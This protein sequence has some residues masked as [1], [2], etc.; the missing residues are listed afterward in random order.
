M[1]ELA[2]T[3]QTWFHGKSTK[4]GKDPGQ[5]GEEQLFLG[6]QGGRNM[7]IVDQRQLVSH[8][9]TKVT[10]NR[11]QRSNGVRN[12]KQRSPELLDGLLWR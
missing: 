8:K 4:C 10:T 1:G 5:L 3:K 9:P 7:D 6:L 11:K 12:V 2:E